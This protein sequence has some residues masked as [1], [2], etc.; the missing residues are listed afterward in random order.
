MMRASRLFNMRMCII[1]P[2]NKK[3]GVI[4]K[5]MMLLISPK[6]AGILDMIGFRLAEIDD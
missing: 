4:A 6:N 5:L 2:S 3:A 1:K